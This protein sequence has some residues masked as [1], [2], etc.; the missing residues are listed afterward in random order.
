[1][2]SKQHQ[3]KTITSHPLGVD[4]E[5][6]CD[7]LIAEC[8]ANLSSVDESLIRRAFRFC[9]DAHKRDVRA[10][11]EPYYTHPLEVARIVVREIP[12]DDVSVAAALLH[13]VAEDTEFDIKDLKAEFGETVAEIVDGATKIEGIFESHEIT[14]AENYRKLL[15]SLI[16][17][18]RVILI[19]FADRLHNMRTLEY[20]KPEKQQRIARETL[21]I[22]APFAHS[23]CSIG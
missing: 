7:L 17:D 21:D 6:D 4:A 23:G 11:G 22:Y 19:K 13:D 15:L 2:K 20:L 5:A 3:L 18:V 9:V 1:M 8:K 12:L 14:Q 16:K 10:S